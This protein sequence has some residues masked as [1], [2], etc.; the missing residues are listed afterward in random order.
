[1]IKIKSKTG[2]GFDTKVYTK[3]GFDITDIGIKDIEIDISAS[4]QITAKLTCYVSELDLNGVKV[5]GMSMVDIFYNHVKDEN[6]KDYFIKLHN[7]QEM[8]KH[9]LKRIN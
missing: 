4:K 9:G 8:R 2:A 7:Y 3:D 1:M 6:P 5:S